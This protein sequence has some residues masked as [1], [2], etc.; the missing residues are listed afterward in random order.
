M[1]VLFN[2]HSTGEDPQTN[3]EKNV[4][5]LP[6]ISSFCL[7]QTS[8]SGLFQKMVVWCLLCDSG[9]HRI[10]QKLEKNSKFSSFFGYKS[11][12]VQI[13]FSKIKIIKFD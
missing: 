8:F 5:I 10:S 2:L 6:E 3:F 13:F 1:F 7:N 12:V 11:L 9:L 4:G